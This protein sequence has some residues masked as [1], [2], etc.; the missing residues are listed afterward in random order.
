MIHS[1]ELS[2]PLKCNVLNNSEH[3]S[4]NELQPLSFVIKK[5]EVKCL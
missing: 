5:R 1:G 4:N 3:K 2:F